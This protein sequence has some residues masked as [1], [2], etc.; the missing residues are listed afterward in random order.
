MITFAKIKS[1]KMINVFIADDFEIV[2]Y[3]LKSHD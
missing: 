2:K 1:T 3:G